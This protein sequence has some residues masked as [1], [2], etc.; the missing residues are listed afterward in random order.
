MSALLNNPAI[1]WFAI[2]VALWLAWGLLG[3]ALL[4]PI[5]I[6]I[7]RI[8]EVNKRKPLPW[9][10]RVIALPLFYFGLLLDW[11]LNVTFYS[12]VCLDFTSWNTLS[13]RL[14]GYNQTQSWHTE[15]GRWRLIV[16]D[17]AEPMLNPFDPDGTHIGDGPA[18]P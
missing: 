11:L 7:Y 14:K 6:A 3:S 16:C 5:Y 1:M 9:V 17:F 4:W 8:K 2:G 18:K 15:L 13:K 10:A 12:V